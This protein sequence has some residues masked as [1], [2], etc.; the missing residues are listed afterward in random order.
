MNKNF[1]TM[2]RRAFAFALSMSMVTSTFSGAGFT[3]AADNNE[4][5][6]ATE[7]IATPSW[8]KSGCVYFHTAANTPSN[9]EAW[10]VVEN[11][12]E[13]FSVS[14]TYSGK[15]R[16]FLPKAAKNSDGKYLVYNNNSSTVKVAGTS[17]A[18]KKTGYVTLGTPNSSGKI[19]TTM[20]V[21]SKSYTLTVYVSEAE[22]NVYFTTN[23]SS[24]DRNNNKIT[25]ANGLASALAVNQSSG[26]TKK[27]AKVINPQ[28]TLVQADGTI[29]VSETGSKIQGRGNTTW[30]NKPKKGWNFNLT[31]KTSVGNMPKAKKYSLV[32]NF[33]DPSLSRDRIAFDL[34]DSCNIA[35]ADS[36]YAN[37]YM[38]GMYVGGYLLTQKYDTTVSLSDEV[39]YNSDGSVKDME[40]M[41]EVACKSQG[42]S[43]EITPASGY[44]ILSVVKPSIEDVTSSQKSAISAFMKAKYKGLYNAVCNSSTT[45]EE[46]SKWIDVESL[47]KIYLLNEVDKNYDAGAQSFYLSYRNGKFFAEP[48]WDYDNGLGN[49]NTTID[50]G[51]CQSPADWWCKVKKGNSQQF[52]GNLLNKVANYSKVT[53]NVARKMWFGESIDDTR[54]M[55]YQIRKFGKATTTNVKLGKNT[56]LL[57]KNYYYSILKTYSYSNY[58][59]WTQ[60][61]EAWC[62]GHS[63]LT[64]YSVDYNALYKS[65]NTNDF[66]ASDVTL[67]TGS[68]SYS[69]GTID[70]E[71]NY[72]CDFLQYR[73]AWLSY[74]FAKKMATHYYLTTKDAGYTTSSTKNVLTLEDITSDVFMIQDVDASSLK[75]GFKFNNGS[76][77]IGCSQNTTVSTSTVYG[78]REAYKASGASSSASAE[79][80]FE[81]KDNWNKVDVFY[82]PKTKEVYVVKADKTVEVETVLTQFSYDSNGKTAEADLDEYAKNDDTYTYVATSGNATLNAV[83]TANTPKHIS[84]STDEYLSE[85]GVNLGLVPVVAASKTNPWTADAGVTV[86]TSATG[87]KNMKFAFTLGASKKGPANYSIYVTDGTNKTVLGTYSIAS[88]KTMYNVSFDVPSQYDYASN[89]TFGITLADTMAV[90]GK[91]LSA[92]ATSGEFAINNVV[93]SGTTTTVVT[94]TIAPTATPTVAPTTAPTQTPTVAPVTTAPVTVAPTTVPTQTPTAAPTKTPTVVPTQTTVGNTVTVYYKRAA[95][96]SWADAYAHYKVGGAWT[97]SP[98]V[99]MEKVSAGYWKLTIALGNTTEAKICF[100][101]GNGSW[102]SNSSKNYMVYAGAYLVDQTTKKVTKIEV[103]EPTAVP[104]A[105]PTTSPVTS[106]NP[107]V[108]PTQ[109][110]TTVPTQVPT[111]APTATPTVVPTQTPIGNTVTV[112]YKRAT[113]T[114]W[115]DAYAHYKVNNGK[116]TTSPGVKMEKVSAGYWKVTINLGNETGATMC[117]NNGK[118]TWDSN[119]SKN[120]TVKAGTYLVDQ[121]KKTVTE[122]K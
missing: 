89:L 69:K 109:A 61:S 49:P 19:S 99:K 97:T 4:V 55:L 20:A 102:D 25:S 83:I 18:S 59:K 113:D 80:V 110:P 88:N 78:D 73:A 60:I 6:T 53:M 41:V 2:K 74:Q 13:K 37:V 62:D 119:S 39:Q 29:D 57:S 84:W 105:T 66:S 121:T 96:T 120:Y 35:S 117:F 47:A 98:G 116:W 72:A 118:G 45:Y 103:Q 3:L 23:G 104:T 68:K 86:N 79:F 82:S 111:V 48:G 63:K 114:S 34:A 70:G 42:D 28:I 92:A 67:S 26:L 85:G 1:M 36:R 112:Y 24:V 108:A 9:A 33:G 71:L 52:E 91:D 77:Y 90:N 51:N 81:N 38:D 122:M 100:N 31:T 101:N 64:S 95:N 65:L 40:F 94:P 16:A 93:I 8:A 87:Y 106:G 75:N 58:K 12:S 50:Y 10:V 11:E 5:V 17:I 46:L 76:S 56:G 30:V 107:T 27:Q 115:T 43:W 15:V 7:Q 14:G 21:G 32:A 54:S 22:E 44:G